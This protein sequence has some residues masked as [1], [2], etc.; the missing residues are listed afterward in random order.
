MGLY[1]YI[2][3]Y[4][5][6]YFINYKLSYEFINNLIVKIII[7]PLKLLRQNLG[8]VELGLIVQEFYFLTIIDSKINY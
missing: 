8:F 2:Y 4:I 3:I 6:N 1:I 5:Y 7:P